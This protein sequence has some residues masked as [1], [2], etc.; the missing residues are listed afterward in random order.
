MLKN[1]DS[2]ILQILSGFG[3]TTLLWLIVLLLSG[4]FTPELSNNIWNATA[5]LRFLLP[6]LLVGFCLL[7]GGKA[8]STERIQF[9]RT[10]CAILILSPLSYPLFLLLTRAANDIPFGQV[11]FLPLSYLL[12]WCYLPFFYGAGSFGDCLQQWFDADW[13]ICTIISM[14]LYAVFIA[15]GCLGGYGLYRRTKKQ[16]LEKNCEA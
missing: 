4:Y 10:V 11:L 13:M 2:I 1:K 8:G 9:Y 14:V 6:F 7:C 5:P 15:A 12:Q 3:I 16:T